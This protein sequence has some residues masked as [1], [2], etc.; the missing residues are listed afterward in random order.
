LAV[1]KRKN[2]KELRKQDLPQTVF[3]AI[4]IISV[5]LIILPAWNYTRYYI[6]LNNF[7]YTLSAVNIYTSNVNVPANGFA[8]INITLLTI[9]PT[10]YSGLVIGTVGANLQYIGNTHQVWQGPGYGRGSGKYV[11]TNLWPLTSATTQ[12]SNGPIGPNSNRTILLEILIKPDFNN[13][14]GPNLDAVNFIDYLATN[15]NKIEWLISCTLPINTFLG[16]F[17]FS[18]TFDRI[19]P[20]NQSAT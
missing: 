1:L 8:K 9:N 4:M 10:D 2:W 19:T 18:K 14:S 3:L 11:S 20:S 12:Q 17:S 15:P 6:A 13:P 7:D 5:S 16:T